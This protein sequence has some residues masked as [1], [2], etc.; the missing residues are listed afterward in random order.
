MIRLQGLA[1]VTW[2]E[3][4]PDKRIDCFLKFLKIHA[5]G[6]NVLFESLK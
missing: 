4:F 5:H 1:T 6:K 2:K 3:E